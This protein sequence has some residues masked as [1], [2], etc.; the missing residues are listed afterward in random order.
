MLTAETAR[1]ALPDGMFG[2][3]GR[4]VLQRKM[5]RIAKRWH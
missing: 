5:Y 1:S 2:G 4:P 3:A